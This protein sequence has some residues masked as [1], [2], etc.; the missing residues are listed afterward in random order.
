MDYSILELLLKE[1]E[2][3]K[4]NSTGSIEFSVFRNL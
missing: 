2:D 3:E 4:D 1:T